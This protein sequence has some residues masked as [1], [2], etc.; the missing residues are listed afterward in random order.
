MTP[1]AHAAQNEIAKPISLTAY[2]GTVVIADVL[3]DVV[4]S[5]QDRTIEMPGLK[6]SQTNTRAGDL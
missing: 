5:M 1:D 3:G 6:S 4:R 2:K